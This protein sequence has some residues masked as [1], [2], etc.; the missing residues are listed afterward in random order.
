METVPMNSAYKNYKIKIDLDL[1]AEQIYVPLHE[2]FKLGRREI[3]CLV[4]IAYGYSILEIANEMGISARTIET[5][6]KNLKFKLNLSL[7]S[8]LV[9][10][11]Y[12][13]INSNLATILSNNKALK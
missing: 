12:R 11:Y 9:G 3:Q 10:F 7:R 4:C 5:Y 13:S 1:I 6:I 8:H 2:N